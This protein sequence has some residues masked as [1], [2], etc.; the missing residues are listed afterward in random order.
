MVIIFERGS[1]YEFEKGL[2]LEIKSFE[3]QDG[4]PWKD[5]FWKLNRSND[6]MVILES[7]IFGN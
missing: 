1:V 5:Y 4:D 3:R 6:K 2:F 7:I